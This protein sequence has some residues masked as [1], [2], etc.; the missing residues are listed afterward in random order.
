[1]ARCTD[2]TY[3]SEAD[4]EGASK[5]WCE[6]AIDWTREAEPVAKFVT[7]SDISGVQDAVA[8]VVSIGVLV[9]ILFAGYRIMRRVVRA[10]GE[11]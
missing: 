8:V 1:M 10:A 9:S 7:C 2:S 5:T 3:T 4:C 6:D 11:A